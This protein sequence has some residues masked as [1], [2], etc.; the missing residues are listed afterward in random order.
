MLTCDGS[1]RKRIWEEEE[2]GKPSHVLRGLQ[3]WV[4][5]TR[6]CPALCHPWPAA[7]QAPLPMDFSRQEC[8]SALPCPSQGIFLLG[9]LHF[10]QVLLLSEP[11]S[12]KEA[13]GNTYRLG[14]YV[15]IYT[16]IHIYIY[17]YIY[18]C[19]YK[20]DK[21]VYLDKHVNKLVYIVN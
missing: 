8:W 10:R 6:S 4:L 21:C 1:F 18:D 11:L 20:L 16:Q 17:T 19:D 13:P 5:V 2:L 12:P 3:C 9:L 15:Y 14:V 7:R